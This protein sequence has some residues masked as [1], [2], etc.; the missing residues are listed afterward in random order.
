MLLYIQESYVHI[1]CVSLEYMLGGSVSI[2]DGCIMLNKQWYEG[3][4]Y[5]QIMINYTKLLH[6]YIVF[7]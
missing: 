3:K 1:L 2:L 6:K 4:C 7:T 5:A